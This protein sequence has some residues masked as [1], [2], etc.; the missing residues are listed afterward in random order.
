MKDFTDILDCDYSFSFVAIASEFKIYHLNS[1]SFH[2]YWPWKASTMFKNGVFFELV[3]SYPYYITT[4][5][6]YSHCA[7]LFC[8][9]CFHW[10]ISVNHLDL[11]MIKI[12]SFSLDNCQ[13]FH[14]KTCFSTWTIASMWTSG[15]R[16]WK[17]SSESKRARAGC[18]CDQGGST[19]LSLKSFSSAPEPTSVVHFLY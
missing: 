6:T 2:G 18:P 13:N 8:V 16:A 12:F 10:R 4:Y 3:F 5:I 14:L 11:M 7:W 19:V 15:V 17:I 9:I 1:T